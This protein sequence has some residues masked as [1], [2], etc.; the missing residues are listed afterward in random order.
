[1]VSFQRSLRT[2]V[3]KAA[4]RSR[5]SSTSVT[6]TSR[7]SE[8]WAVDRKAAGSDAVGRRPQ[9]RRAPARC[10]RATG[11]GNCGAAPGAVPSWS[12]SPRT[13]RTPAGCAG[14]PGGVRGTRFAQRRE[15]IAEQVDEADVESGE[16]VCLGSPHAQRTCSPAWQ[17]RS[18]R[19]GGGRCARPSA[20]KCPA[21][22]GCVTAA[23]MTGTR[24]GIADQRVGCQGT[25]PGHGL[26]FGDSCRCATE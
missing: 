22:R 17:I 7:D 8:V 11:R 21:P 23:P 16:Q 4:G 10:A 12:G 5:R 1:M 14:G 2:R 13:R 18:C 26:G 25:D 20:R 6:S 15:G 3:P 19:R 24:V 9:R